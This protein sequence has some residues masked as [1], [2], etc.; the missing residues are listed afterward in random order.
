MNYKYIITQGHQP[1]QDDGGPRD[2]ERHSTGPRP[3]VHFSN[4]SMFDT[5]DTLTILFSKIY[6]LLL[7]CIILYSL[8]IKNIFSTIIRINK[9]NK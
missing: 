3:C 9:I 7:Y 6:I 8:G 4:H 2:S 1:L 5:M